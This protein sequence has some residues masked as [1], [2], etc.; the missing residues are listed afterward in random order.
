MQD[1]TGQIL[2]PP[3]LFLL[4]ADRHSDWLRGNAK[5]RGGTAS[6]NDDNLKND[7]KT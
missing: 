2:D 6:K 7:F 5:P 4:K 3:T 1:F